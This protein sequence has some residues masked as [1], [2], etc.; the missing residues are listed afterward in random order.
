MKLCQITD[1]DP[2][3]I[4]LNF[5]CTYDSAPVSIPKKTYITSFWL[6]TKLNLLQFRASDN[7]VLIQPGDTCYVEETSY[8]TAGFA[9]H[10]MFKS[11][12]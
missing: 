1:N 8:F 3:I 12:A 9:L 2:I 5:R 7:V 11:V 6:H 10:K 4:V